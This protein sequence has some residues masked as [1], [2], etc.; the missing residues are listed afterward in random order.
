MM[1][2]N[3]FVEANGIEFVRLQDVTYIMR[4]SYIYYVSACIY[5][6]AYLSGRSAPSIFAGLLLDDDLKNILDK[7]ID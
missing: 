6:L 1:T 5:E 2:F 3:E 7:E 4:D